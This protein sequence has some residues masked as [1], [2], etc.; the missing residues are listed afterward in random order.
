MKRTMLTLIPVLF[1]ALLAVPVQAPAATRAVPFIDMNNNG[2]FDSGD[3]DVSAQ[4]NGSGVVT[5]SESI[6]VPANS[7]T[8]VNRA[9][10]YTLSAGKNVTI[11]SN[12]TAQGATIDVR[13]E[14]G[15]IVVGPRV[16]LLAGA[17]QLTAQ[18]DVLIGAQAG[19]SAND[20]YLMVEAIDGAVV[21]GD[22]VQLS[23]SERVEINT[24]NAGGVKLNGATFNA[25]KGLINLHVGGNAELVGSKLMGADVNVSSDGS[26]VDM[27]DG[28]VRAAPRSGFVFITVDGAGSKLDCSDT[29]WGVTAD[30]RVLEADTVLV[31]Y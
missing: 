8:H 4:L 18:V 5:T 12:L 25:M 13:S 9:Y 27:H 29:R 7:G 20:S 28:Y 26:L 11:L 6:V 1:A 24:Y 17:I 10:G 31:K 2:V 30:N 15:S 3:V 14:T 22:G 21:G 23:G 16:R 19:F